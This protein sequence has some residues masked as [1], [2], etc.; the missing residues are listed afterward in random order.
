MRTLMSLS[1]GVSLTA[2]LA[3]CSS[4]PTDSTDA[5][6]L[7][8]VTVAPSVAALERG[9]SLWLR[10]ELEQ[11]DGT[12][13]TPSNLHWRSSDPSV[14][15]VASGGLVRGVQ[16]G[17]VQIVAESEGTTGSAS[18]T[19]LESGGTPCIET[20]LA[21]TAVPPKEPKGHGCR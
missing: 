7:G 17:R 8:V 6:G 4:S 19:V 2:L 1:A 9:A 12:R 18:V 14:A 10:A 21:G 16:A 13:S 15:T 20:M 5:G 3:A 11:T